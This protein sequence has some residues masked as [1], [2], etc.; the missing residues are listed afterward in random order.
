MG[1]DSDHASSYDEI[2]LAENRSPSMDPCH[3]GDP[4][5]YCSGQATSLQRDIFV[6]FQEDGLTDRDG[7]HYSVC[8]LQ[9]T[10]IQALRDDG[11]L[12][13]I[14]FLKGRTDSG[15]AIAQQ[16]ELLDGLTKLH[17]PHLVGVL[18]YGEV[19]GQVFTIMEFV[20]AGSLQDILLKVG[21]LK[22][23]QA[24][25]Y[26]SDLLAGL[27]Y[28]HS[29]GVVH[30]NIKPDNV[31]LTP[32]GRCKLSDFG[33]M[34]GGARADENPNLPSPMQLALLCRSRNR[35]AA[36]LDALKSAGT[37]TS[38]AAPEVEEGHARPTHGADI[39]SVGLV[40]LHLVT[41]KGEKRETRLRQ[42]LSLG[43]MPGSIP[44]G[45]LGGR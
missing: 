3:D 10:V 5:R 39:W 33:L 8:E 36:F 45:Q 25:A 37:T 35:S 20:G 11:C 6:Q 44:W 9:G 15:E 40:A 4:L 17:H 12:V 29:H 19:Y 13:A 34:Q 30:G 27:D 42:P 14:K 7:A 23:R 38:Y 22:P 21:L 26:I 28:L 43:S 1:S 31:L 16:L 18:G 32:E 41:G 24:A 2:C